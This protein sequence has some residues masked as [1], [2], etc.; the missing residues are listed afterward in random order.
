MVT[1]VLSVEAQTEWGAIAS[2]SNQPPLAVPNTIQKLPDKLIDK[3][4]IDR[5]AAEFLT[6]FLVDV[7]INFLTGSAIDKFATDKFAIDKF[8][9][10]KLVILR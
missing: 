5:L 2:W 3:V 6:N 10:D 7:L 1:V 9:I 4:A 8:L